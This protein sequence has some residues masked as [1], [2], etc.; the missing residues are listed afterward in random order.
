[1]IVLNNME[2]VNDD[3]LQGNLKYCSIHYSVY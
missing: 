3:L 2:V 1:M